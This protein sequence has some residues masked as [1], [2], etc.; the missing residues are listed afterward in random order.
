MP[1]RRRPR[2]IGQRHSASSTRPSPDCRRVVR[3]SPAFPSP[4]ASRSPARCRRAICGSRSEACGPPAR[5]RESR[6][7]RRWRGRNG[8][9]VPGVSSASCVWWRSR[10]MR[11]R[12]PETRRSGRSDNPLTGGSPRASS[13]RT[14]STA[15]SSRASWSRCASRPAS[16]RRACTPLA[17]ATTGARPARAGPCWCSAQATSRPSPPWMSSPSSSTKARCACSR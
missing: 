4:I 17:P 12:A 6:L 7:A 5:P 13:R 16:T 9:R 2:R 11:S 15:C 8:P 1:E 14:G 10:S 3:R